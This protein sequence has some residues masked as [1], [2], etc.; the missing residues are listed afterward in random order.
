M[1]ALKGVFI[2]DLEI[3]CRVKS[4]LVKTFFFS[5]RKAE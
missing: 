2:S 3:R 5:D 4:D 1:C